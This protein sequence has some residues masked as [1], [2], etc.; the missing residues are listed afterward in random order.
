VIAILCSGVALGVY[1]PGLILRRDLRARGVPAEVFVLEEL[2]PEDKR[3]ALARS[4]VAFH[5]SFRMAVAGHRL[6]RDITPLL[7]EG[8]VESQLDRWREQACRTFVVLSGFWLPLLDRYAATALTPLAV[9]LCH[10]DSIDS[11]SFRVNAS[12]AERY[13]RR[14]LLDVGADRIHCAIWTSQAPPVPFGQRPQRFLSHGGGWGMGTYAER[15]V[16]LAQRGLALD[17]IA[18]HED[19]LRRRA[20]G[21]RSFMIDPAWHPWHRDAKGEHG[22]PPFSEISPDGPAAFRA[23]S[24]HHDGFSLARESLA[25]IS[26]PGGGTLL[27]SLAAATPVVL[28]EPLGEHEQRNAELWERLGFGVP[29]DRWLESGCSREFLE[30]LHLNLVAARGSVADYAAILA[31]ELG[32]C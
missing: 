4:K 5:Q 1:V 32:S 31:K 18:Y 23:P 30:Q 25:M 21:G 7:D 19:D 6:A 22:F 29:V 8:A 28:L 17:V 3:A 26:K 20:P 2:Y 11:P 14:R 10:I 16:E 12:R 15:S 9:E 13:R 24:E 27:D